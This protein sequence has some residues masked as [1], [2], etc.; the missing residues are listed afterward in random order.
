MKKNYK[1][2]IERTAEYFEKFSREKVL[3]NLINN[4]TPTLIDVGANMGQTIEFFLMNWPKAKI[5]AFEPQVECKEALDAIKKK[6]SNSDLQIIEKACGN[7]SSN[8]ELKFYSHNIS[9][10]LSGF[11]RLNI[12]SIDSIKLNG[13]L[14]IEKSDYINYLTEINHER[15]VKCVR[16][17]EWLLE[18]NV[19]RVDLLKIDTQGFEPEVLEGMGGLLGTVKV[20]LSELMLYDLYERSLSF[21]DIEKYLH[22]AGLRLYDI[23][24]ISKNPMNGRTDWVDVIYVNKLVNSII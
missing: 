13:E 23:S 5:I 17:D 2:N 20:V 4:E 1:T 7:A 14:K 9:S 24:H 12:N 11:N 16:L 18:N 3:L 21:S 19:S 15:N 8:N 6:Y 10:G 22:P